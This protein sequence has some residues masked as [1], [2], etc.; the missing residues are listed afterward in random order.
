MSNGVLARQDSA[1]NGCSALAYMVLTA[2]IER[3]GEGW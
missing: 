2:R 3:N 1:T